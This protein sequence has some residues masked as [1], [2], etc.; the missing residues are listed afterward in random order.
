MLSEDDILLPYKPEER[1]EYFRGSTLDLSNGEWKVPGSLLM[2]MCSN[3]GY[4]IAQIDPYNT[5][6][7][8][9]ENNNVAA[10]PVTVSHCPGKF[11]WF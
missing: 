4:I 6:G 1:D 5:V 11:K 8:A 9:N 3:Q 10:L 2:F 7:E